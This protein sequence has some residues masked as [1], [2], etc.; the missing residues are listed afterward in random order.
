MSNKN[1]WF[2]N[3]NYSRRIIKI[4]E[5]LLQKYKFS[6]VA[7]QLKWFKNQDH[8]FQNV[9]FLSNSIKIIIRYVTRKYEFPVSFFKLFILFFGVKRFLLR[10]ENVV[11]FQ[12]FVSSVGGHLV[13]SYMALRTNRSIPVLVCTNQLAFSSCPPLI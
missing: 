9:M 13:T 8:L 10:P 7:L 4:Y 3:F 1:K 2:I 5:S 12:C 6:M 11:T